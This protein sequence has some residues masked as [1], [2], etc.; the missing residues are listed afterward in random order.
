MKFSFDVFPSNDDKQVPCAYLEF[1]EYS[2]Q[3]DDGRTMNGYTCSLV[4]SWGKVKLTP[5][6]FDSGSLLGLLNL[7][8]SISEAD[9]E[10]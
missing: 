8:I 2:F 9:E 6:G 5:K 10:I 7:S 1:E 4:F 3:T